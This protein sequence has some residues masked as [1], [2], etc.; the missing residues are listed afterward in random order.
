MSFI[1]KKFI[2]CFI[3]LGIILGSGLIVNHNSFS[4]NGAT[5]EVTPVMYV[6]DLNIINQSF[7]GIPSSNRGKVQINPP[8]ITVTSHTTQTYPA[9]TTV[10]LKAI[11]STTLPGFPCLFS[12]W[13]G[14]ISSTQSQVNL[15]MD[16]NKSVTALFKIYSPTITP[17]RRPTPRITV[18][19]IQ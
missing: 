19:P 15:L 18:I 17:T 9:G 2:T 6:L 8:G 16:G 3:I 14:D 13:S 12:S 4:V 11:N 1:R 7:G 5:P 10:T